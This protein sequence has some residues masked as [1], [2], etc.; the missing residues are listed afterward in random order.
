MLVI[1]LFLLALVCILIAWRF[2]QFVF[3]CSIA[4]APLIGW[5]VFLPTWSVPVLHRIFGDTLEVGVAELVALV[6]VVV[7]ILW[8][9]APT[10]SSSPSERGR[11][12]FLFPLLIPFL[13]LVLAHL[14]SAFSPAH[15]DVILVIKYSLRPVLWVYVTSIFLPTNFIRTRKQ[16]LIS[17]LVLVGVGVLFSID[18][19]RS[20]AFG[21][22]D[23]TVLPRAH[24]LPYFGTYP[25]GINHNVLGELLVVCAPFA[26][27]AGMLARSRSSRVWLHAS[28]IF[29][30]L[31]A[32]LTFA[33]SAWIALLC[34]VIFLCA[35]VWRPWIRR[36]VAVVVFL[37]L[38]FLPLVGFMVLFTS[39]SGVASSTDTRAM[40]S[41]IALDQFRG[42][43]IFGVGA[44]TF[45]Q[46]V[47][48]VWLF[49]FEFGGPLD[50]HGILQ[51]LAAET[52]LL[53]LAAFVF[54]LVCLI[55]RITHHLPPPPTP[56]PAG[57]VPSR[58]AGVDR[59]VYFYLVAAVIGAFVYQLFNTT[60]WTPKLWLPVGI[61]FAYH[62]ISQL[63]AKS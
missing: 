34:E 57:G 55:K 62:G 28:A 46:R 50:S 4:T 48:S 32:F 8:R 22:D 61:L 54:L 36:H 33:R 9:V 24:P 30:T 14:F 35:T 47:S 60:Y 26:L 3:Y 10:P 41:S 17:L 29:M 12:K 42:S 44:G 23:Q 56:P 38:A 63:K 7:L 19:L 5:T 13:L 2:P 37:L 39:Q 45:V 21:S 43:P 16:F 53:G 27:V 59:S 58:I 31:I 6:L 18:G 52:G 40:L 49:H 11:I 51:K 15:P 1:L 25:I 20:M